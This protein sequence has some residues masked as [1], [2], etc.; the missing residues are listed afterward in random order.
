[1]GCAYKEVY[2]TKFVNVDYVKIGCSSDSETRCE[3]LGDIEW[4]IVVKHSNARFLESLFHNALAEY[5]VPRFEISSS[6]GATEYFLF[7]CVDVFIKL[8]SYLNLEYLDYRKMS[9]YSKKK[10]K[11]SIFKEKYDKVTKAY[12]KGCRA[13][14]FMHLSTKDLSEYDKLE[15]NFEKS[16]YTQCTVHPKFK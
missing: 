4:M 13:A 2:L 12:L 10:D 5:R 1:M 14:I 3:R 7:E 11:N 15:K 9:S 16:L 8:C 6:D